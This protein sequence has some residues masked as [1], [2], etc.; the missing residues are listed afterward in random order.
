MLIQSFEDRNFFLLRKSARIK[1]AK[2]LKS[3]EIQK[4]SVCTGCSYPLPTQP[5]WKDYLFPMDVKF[6]CYQCRIDEAKKNAL[7]KLSNL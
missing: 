3:G 5:I 1:V 7:D 6:L 4:P 2:A